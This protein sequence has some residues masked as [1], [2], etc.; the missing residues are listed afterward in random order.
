MPCLLAL[1]SRSSASFRASSASLSLSSFVFVEPWGRKEGRKGDRMEG[2]KGGACV[3]L[4]VQKVV[5]ICMFLH[6]SHIYGGGRPIK[7]QIKGLK[8]DAP[9]PKE[10]PRHLQS[11]PC[12]SPCRRRR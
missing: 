3:R 11:P 8:L 12:P 1:A 10:I 4:E 6:K 7:N 5:G 9:A 2:W